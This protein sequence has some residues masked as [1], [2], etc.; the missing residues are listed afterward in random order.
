MI[1]VS[2]CISLDWIFVIKSCDCMSIYPGL[3]GQKQPASWYAS[4][5]ILVTSYPKLR[6][7]YLE[8]NT[9]FISNFLL[10]L[11]F[12]SSS[13]ICFTWSELIRP[14]K[15]ETRLPIPRLYSSHCHLSHYT[16][17]IR[18]S[19]VQTTAVVNVDLQLKLATIDLGN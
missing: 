10:F 3:Q 18:R 9:D 2:N 6:V 13:C 4:L 16:K 15:L 12:L 11:S 7:S 17:S 19:V 5:L 1:T 8:W 14:S